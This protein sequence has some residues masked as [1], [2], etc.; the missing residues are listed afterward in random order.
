MEVINMV[1]LGVLLG[2]L[3]WNLLRRVN[4]WVYE[5][6]KLG[7]KRFLLPPG[8]LGLPFIGN[9]LTFLRAFKSTDPD[10]FA[11][12]LV[13]RYGRTGIYKTFMFGSPSILVTMPDTCKRVLTDDDCF[14][15]GWP[16]STVT[17]IGEKSFI[18]ISQ[19]EHKR[20]R[21]LTAAPINGQEALSLYLEFIDEKVVLALDKWSKM[22]QIELLTQLRKL[23][24]RIIMHIFLSTEGEEVME[25][26]EK[27]YT[28]LNYGVRAMAINIPGF[29]YHKA[30]KARK[31]MVAI[32]QSVVNERR[33]R[34]GSM[35][36]SPVGKKGDMMDALLEVVDD[37]GRRLGDDDIIDI[38]VMYLN[39][40]HESSGH[41]AM[42]AVFY[43]HK[44]PEVFKKAKAEQEAIVRNRPPG[45]KR[46]SLK[47]YR[48]M[49]YTS[50]VI[51][52]TLRIVSFSLMVFRE[53]LKDVKI[54]GY[55]IPKGWKVLAWFRSVHFDSEIYPNPKEFD[56]SRWDGFTPKAGSF[57]PFGA[58]TRLCPG[59]DLAK[60]E[61]SVFL[62]HYL[63]GYE[64]ERANPNS[65]LMYLP[66]PRPMDNC[67]G[68]MKKVSQ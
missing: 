7:D 68:R 56:P 37:K 65:R 49:E 43:L 41:T 67:L 26:L 25:D 22:G 64:F 55:L 58:G 44:H 35:K 19:E 28:F 59:N 66:H 36:N 23:T 48:Q 5:N 54:N 62:H 31:R 14:M 33:K 53:A 42:W 15:P 3:V 50:Q 1:L 51:D 8:D 17:L 57:L 12:S 24:F 45:Q 18:G 11:N 4:G 30:L 29:A 60:L 46:M 2:G 61:I 40:G 20:L 63:L 32:F 39:A 6:L 10:S 34:M 47:E 16:E 27:E 13:T 9:M 52:E 21:K 38:L